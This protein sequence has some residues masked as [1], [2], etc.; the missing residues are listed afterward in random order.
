MS[1]GETAFVLNE[2]GSG[3]STIM[4]HDTSIT[5]DAS[6]G[7]VTFRI[8]DNPSF[9]APAET[10]TARNLLVVPLGGT[11]STIMGMFMN[12]LASGHLL[13]V[14]AGATPRTFALDDAQLALDAFGRCVAALHS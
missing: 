2:F 12:Q 11:P 14:T 1:R 13:K 3:V 7:S 6:G 8:D 10:D 9:T 5:W 4:F